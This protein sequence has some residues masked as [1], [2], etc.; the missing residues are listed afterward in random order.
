MAVLGFELRLP[1]YQ[2]VL[3][4]WNLIPLW[5]CGKEGGRFLLTEAHARLYGVMTMDF[6]HERKIYCGVRELRV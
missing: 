1:C 4:H 6:E 2:V 5:T 3:F